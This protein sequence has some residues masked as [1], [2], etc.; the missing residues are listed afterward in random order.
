MKK[1]R[2]NLHGGRIP[3]MKQILRIMKLTSVLLFAVFFQVSATVFSQTNG[4]LNLKAENES[5]SNILKTIEEQTE[6]RFL[7]NSNNINVDRKTDIDCQSKNVEEVLQILFAGTDVTYRSFNTNYVLFSEKSGSPAETQQ[8]RSVTGKVTDSTGGPLPGVSVILKGTTIGVIT[9][10]NGKYS[11]SNIPANAI[12]QFSFVG[13]KGQEIAVGSKALINVTLEDATIGI[14]EVV[15]IGYGTQ[16]K[17]AVTGAVVTADLG[18]YEKVPTNNVMERLKGTVAGLNVG[19]ANTAGGVPGFT[20]RG[21][22]S[23]AAS[24]TPLIVLDG[25][26]FRGTMAD[27]SPSD[28][29]S[30]TV[31]KDASAAAV[32]GSRSSNGVIII[33]TKKGTGLDGKPKF[34]LQSSYGVVNELKPL[35]VYNAQ[36]YMQRLNDILNDNGTVVPLDQ[37]SNYLQTIEKKNYDATPDHQPTLVDPYGMFRQTGFNQNTSL[38]VSN[39]TD[40]MNYFMSGNYTSQKGVILNDLFKHY[41]IRV[42]LESKITDWLT[43]GLK[44]YFSTRDYPQGRIYGT[45][46]NT[47]SYAFSPY[48]DIYNADGSYKQFPQTTTSFNSPYWAIADDS[49]NKAYNLNGIFNAT[50]KVPWV[51]GL[52]Y[53]ATYA[54]TLNFSET[55]SFYGYQTIVGL[56]VNGQGTAN[57]GRSNTTMLDHLVKFSRTFAQKHNVD[58]TLLYST[59]KYNGFNQSSS[60]KGFDNP[61]LGVYRLQA[62]QTPTVSTG[63][64]ETKA[65]GQMARLTYTFNDKYGITGT[66]R[67]DGY[68]AFSANKKYG[69]FPSV[70]VNWNIYKESFMKNISF[71]DVLT[72]RG[73]YGTNG[74]QSISPYST[75]A[76]VGNSYYYYQGDTN[77]TMTE[78]ISA[79]GN[80]NLGWESRTGYN[81]GIDFSV[82]KHRISGS[83]DMYSTKTNDLAFTLN[84]P[85]A[86]GFGSITANAGEIKNKGIEL[87]LSTLNMQKGMF[88]WTSDIAFS[89]NRNKVS[90]LLGDTNGDGIEDDIVSSGLFIGKSLGTI[91]TYKVTG[92]YQQTD[93]DNGTILNGF[94][95]G[96]YQLQDVNTDG[97]I[98][99]DQDRQFIGISKENFRWSFTNTFS[100]GKLSLLVYLNSI[101]GGNNYFLS[102]NTPYLDGYANRGD[103]NH[104]VYDYWTPTNTG[105]E[106]PRP[107]YKD[108][109]TFKGNKYYD[110]SFIRLQ[111][112]ALNYDLTKVAKKYGIQKLDLTL[113]ADNL[114]TYAPQWIGLDASTA[115]G[116]TDN[117]I[118]SLRTV[119]LGLNINF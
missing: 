25:S 37:T 106:F 77:Y 3:C 105:A 20:I 18:T 101:W 26:I 47:S 33:E 78:Y 117:S 83:I 67:R 73:S 69:D 16:K 38:S 98:T 86:S 5:I 40:K 21:Q 2:W 75:L 44:S 29:E 15:A 39:R 82:L 110:R 43:V 114:G 23:I 80:D 50:V 53:T 55:G 96:Y 12:L 118:P 91:Y 14:E 64:S 108:K 46:S 119:M 112:I 58:L 71:L 94:Q 103:L 88:Q 109:A 76:K 13:M 97:K 17:Q 35:E 102:N 27:I 65:V 93:K 92:M 19:E 89:L 9:D 4:K 32:Y 8:Q 113:S 90:H 74:N 66:Y 49:Y 54:H 111:K 41:S 116:L 99:S 70:G 24:G 63:G 87:N 68:S 30:V 72:F 95:P 81:V 28:I 57:F 7:Y 31:L 61:Q 84:L 104:A 6:F 79:L 52:S 100:Y 56:P 22:N 34:S 107:S 59:E 85:G 36:G 62:G 48:A 45:G 11:L 10:F 51:K 42:N 60:S 1:K 115:A